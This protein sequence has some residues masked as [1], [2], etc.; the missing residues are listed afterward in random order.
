MNTNEN[1]QELAG[2]IEEVK[3][4]LTDEEY[5]EIL[6]MSAKLYKKKEPK[7]F[8][9]VLEFSSGK[10]K[11]LN[12]V[13]RLLEVAKKEDAQVYYNDLDT[14]ISYNNY[15]QLKQDSYKHYVFKGSKNSIPRVLVFVSEKRV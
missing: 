3:E 2:K 12:K 11:A 1:L 6:E 10:G 4:K 5:K 7:I 9:E 13:S 14:K 15:I 8:V